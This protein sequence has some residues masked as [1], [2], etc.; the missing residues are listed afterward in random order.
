MDGWTDGQT[1]RQLD[2]QK[3]LLFGSTCIVDADGDG[4]HKSQ[5]SNG[6]LGLTAIIRVS[7]KPVEIMHN[8]PTIKIVSGNEHLVCLTWNHDIFTMG[9]K[10]IELGKFPDL[11]RGGRP[12][13]R[14]LVDSPLLY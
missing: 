9:M 4:V 5:D 10:K 8:Y 1:D 2:R 7:L 3:L 12:P 14:V 13:A 11:S 6:E